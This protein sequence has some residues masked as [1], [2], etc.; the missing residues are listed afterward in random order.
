MGNDTSEV[1][2]TRYGIGK[3]SMFR[4]DIRTIY[5]LSIQNYFDLLHE[6]RKN[7]HTNGRT[8]IHDERITIKM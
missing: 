7:N 2:R 1:S 3:F 6:Q 5:Q 4:N 8:R